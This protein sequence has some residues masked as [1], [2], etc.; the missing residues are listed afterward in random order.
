MSD[1]LFLVKKAHSRQAG[2]GHVDDSLGSGRGAGLSP[3]C[4]KRRKPA[5][6]PV[7]EALMYYL[8]ALSA[9]LRALIKLIGLV[10][11]NQSSSAKNKKK[12]VLPN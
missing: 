10:F 12:D 7:T 3:F 5:S 9:L 4:V 1:K 2:V 6:T 8:F 11:F